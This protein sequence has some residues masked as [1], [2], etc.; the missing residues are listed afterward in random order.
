M[1]EIT[2]AKLS[3]I[4]SADEIKSALNDAKNIA[5]DSFADAEANDAE[6]LFPL[7][8]IS[9]IR[10][11]NLFAAILPKKFGGLGIG[12]ENGTTLEML[13]LHKHFGYGNLVVGRVFEGH[14]NALLLIKLFGTD[15][16][17]KTYADDVV[18]RNKIFGVWNT[19]ANDGVKF[20]PIGGDKFK[21]SGAKI[22]A[23]G[24]DFVERPVVN[25]VLPDGGWQMCVVEMEKIKTKIDPSWWKPLGM[26][27]SRSYRVDFTGVEVSE[28][29]FIGNAG[30]Y[31]RQPYFSG[32]AIRFAA[33]QLGGAEAL[34]DLTR[35]YLQNLKRTE[36]A[37]QKIRVGEMAI[38]VE[39]GNLWLRGAAEKLDEYEKNP[40]AET[41]EK[42]L[43][44]ADMMR[45]AI[46]QI[47]QDVMLFCERCVGARGLNK[48][49]YFERIIRD[50]TIY[51]RQPAPDAS[52]ADVGKYV[53]ET[54]TKADDLWKN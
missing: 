27:S 38:R 11:K 12:L 8:T 49:F 3:N 32:G 30:D 21:M 46:E 22:F 44:Y 14:Y 37:Y 54:K 10:D 16:Q 41:S 52:L 18:K 48:P 42:F 15:E 47:C 19:E 9:K 40:N 6:D 7:K 51:L 31:Y 13:R 26:K 36:D 2:A 50:L 5:Q 29:D 23:T 34:F 24:V 28:T 45:T 4:D 33:V 17:I 43:I 39:S 35:E 53:L 1:P 20:E 25:G